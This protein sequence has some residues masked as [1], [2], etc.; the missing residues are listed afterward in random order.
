MA[1]F[2]NRAEMTTPTT[3]T[4]TITLGTAPS[5][6]Q[7]FSAAGV[8]NGDTVTYVIEDGYAWEIGNGVYASS[9]PTMSRSLVASSTGSL[10]SLSGSAVVSVSFNA[11]TITDIYTQ[12]GLKAPA[13]SPVFTGQVGFGGTNFF[14]VTH[15]AHPHGALFP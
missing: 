13:A 12:L 5:G 8:A 1:T 10:I 6:F 9:G 11:E 4:G 14:M 15:Q 3:G 2:V 7:S